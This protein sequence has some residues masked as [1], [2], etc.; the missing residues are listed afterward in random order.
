MDERTFERRL[1]GLI[2][3]SNLPLTPVHIA[4]HL[5]IPIAEARRHLD[6]LVSAAV[7]ELDSDERGNIFYKY[8]LR[9]PLETLAPPTPPRRRRRR[10]RGRRESTAL[11]VRTT[12]PIVTVDD[13]RPASAVAAAALSLFLPGVGQ[14]YSGRV[15]Q[16]IGWMLATGV[17]YLLFLVPGLILHICCIVNAALGPPR[18]PVLTERA[19]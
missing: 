11:A 9:P 4:Y 16:G 14:I 12:E 2:F 7:L 8:P 6:L 15:L 19:A 10:R 1:L 18:L 3:R 17:G 13:D 5:D